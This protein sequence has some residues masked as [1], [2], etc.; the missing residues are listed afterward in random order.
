MNVSKSLLLS[1]FLLMLLVMGLVFMATFLS[2]P[3]Y[4]DDK[5]AANHESTSSVLRIA[6]LNSISVDSNM[7]VFSA[8]SNGCTGQ[9]DFGLLVEGP[10]L[11]VLRLKQ[12]LCR[13]MP[14]WKQFKLPLN[15]IELEEWEAFYIGNPIELHP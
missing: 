2:S 14:H 12:D 10:E 7:L 13:K 8:K 11:I 4:A 6:T 9:Q 15:D 3:V 1:V 5:A